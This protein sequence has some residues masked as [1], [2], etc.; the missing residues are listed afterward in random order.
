M[1][2]FSIG[3]ALGSGFRV[4]GR[5]PA[6]ALVWGLAYLVIAVGPIVLL[7]LMMIPGI[8]AAAQG[9][10]AAESAAVM[11]MLGPIIAFYPISILASLTAQAVLM[12]GA[13][14]AVLEPE[15]SRFAYLR[16]SG[17]ELWLAL[18]NIVMAFVLGIGALILLIPFMGLAGAAAMSGASTS[19]QGGAAVVAV[20]ALAIG[21]AVLIWVA[22]RLSL[23]FP[24]TFAHRT[25][26]LFESWKLTK[27]N[28]LRLL[29]LYI[30]VGLVVM[31]V[32]LVLLGIGGG[33]MFG[34]VG[35]NLQAI[36]SGNLA[37][38]G[39]GLLA[40]FVIG[41]V[42]MSGFIGLVSLIAYAPAAEAYRQ[43][44]AES[45][46]QAAVFA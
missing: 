10:D 26:R 34:L 19:V 29:G 15:A 39:V 35:G 11:S 14:R 42:L 20:L 5:K 25:F 4:L 21:V 16:L 7:G 30:C 45:G 9:G 41:L 46:R 43:L 23:A 38:V 36:E 12:G 32:Y 24:M 28:T 33:L 44:S 27:G 31:A 37:G 40:A 22:V 17:Q 13:Y 8:V 3:E 18:V 2:S 6:I 1:A